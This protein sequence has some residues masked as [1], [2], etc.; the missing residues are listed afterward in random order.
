MK[1]TRCGIC[2]QKGHWHRECPEK[3]NPK[4]K[5]QGQ[6]RRLAA[7]TFIGCDLSEPITSDMLNGWKIVNQ[8]I[9]ND[10]DA[11][12]VYLSGSA[13]AQALVD[14]GAGGDLVGLTSLNR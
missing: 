10:D 1:V 7:Y 6:Q 5:Q 4:F 3:D 13:A 12:L 8:E 9:Q 2:K 11:T 14:P